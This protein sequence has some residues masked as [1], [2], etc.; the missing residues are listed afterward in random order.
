MSREPW[1]LVAFA[2]IAIL[3]GSLYPFSFHVPTGD[4]TALT[5]FL[6][7]WR[8]L[9]QSRGD[10]LANLLFYFPFGFLFVRKLYDKSSPFVTTLTVGA[11]GALLSASMELLQFYDAGRVSC[12]SDFYLNSV[13]TLLGALA[14]QLWSRTLLPFSPMVAGGSPFAILLLSAWLVWRLF[15]YEPVIDLHKYWASIKPVVLTPSLNL[16]DIFRFATM[17]TTVAYLAQFGLKVRSPERTIPFAVVC[18]FLAKILI[19]DQVVTLPEIVGAIFALVYFHVVLQS[20]IKAGTRILA[21]LFLVSIVLERLLPFQ[22]VVAKPFEWI[23]FY[24]FLHGSM[25]VN[26]QSLAQKVFMYGAGS[27]AFDRCGVGSSHSCAIRVPTPASD[28]R[29]RDKSGRQI[30]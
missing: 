14:A 5:S 8:S 12:M 23:P 13:G 29:L 4:S 18:V 15:P 22:M 3:Y 6:A 9:P 17:W 1:T 20:H 16:Y 2:V 26:L 30:C 10:L 25:E 27:V 24:S 19:V 11:V 21:V 28:E 7:T